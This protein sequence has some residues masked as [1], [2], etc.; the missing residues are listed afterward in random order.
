MNTKYKLVLGSLLLL[1]TQ[2]GY[3]FD[4][5]A[6]TYYFDNTEAKWNQVY[7]RI[8]QTGTSK[9]GSG[10]VEVKPMTQMAGNANIWSYTLDNSWNGAEAVQFADD[11]GCTSA[12]NGIYDG[13][14][15]TSGHK[16]EY[17]KGDVIKS[18]G[19]FLFISTTGVYDGFRSLY[20]SN[21]P[22]GLNASFAI[23]GSTYYHCSGT[24]HDAFNGKCIGSFTAG[25]TFNLNGEVST[26][27]TVSKVSATMNYNNNNAGFKQLN[28]KY[29]NTT[30]S[31]KKGTGNGVAIAVPKSAGKYNLAVYFQCGGVYDSNSGSNYT[32]YYYVPGMTASSQNFGT[33]QVSATKTNTVNI[34]GIYCDD[35]TKSIDAEIVGSGF[36]FDDGNTKKTISSIGAT[37]TSA[38]VKISFKPTVGDKYAAKLN[39]S[40][41][42]SSSEEK[43]TL[44]VD[45]TGAG[46]ANAVVLIGAEAEVLAGPSAT[47]HGYLQTTGCPQNPWTSKGFIYST[48]KNDITAENPTGTNLAA[49][50]SSEI[51]AGESWSAT[52][53]TL[54]ANT[55]YYY[56]AYVK[57]DASPAQYKYSDPDKYGQFTTKSA[58]LYPMVGDTVYV[59]VDNSLSGNDDC[60]LKYKTFAAA[61]TK[62]ITSDFFATN[63]LKY[64]VVM[65]VVPNKEQYLENVRIEGINNSNDY[66][67]VLII[68]SAGSERPTIQQ[69][70][71]TN[72]AMDI[73]VSKNI[74][75]DNIRI[76]SSGGKEA[77]TIGNNSNAWH[78]M[79][80][81]AVANAN[82]VIKNCYIESDGF[83]GVQMWAYDGV[84]FENNDIECKLGSAAKVDENTNYY[85]SSLK[86]QQTKNL[87]FIRNNFRGSHATSLWIQG[88]EG[89]LFMNNVFWNSNDSYYEGLKNNTCFVRLVTQFTTSGSGDTH[90]TANNNKNISM[91]YNTFFLADNSNTTERNVDF[92]RLGSQY[93]YGGKRLNNYLG[94]NEVS[95]IRFM[96]NNCYSYDKHGVK[97]SNN[98]SGD[99]NRWYLTTTESSWC[100][101]IN[102]NNFWSW[103]DNVAES[104]VSVFNIPNA[105]C[106]TPNYFVNV[107]EQVCSATNDPSDLIVKGGDMNFGSHITSDID[108]SGLNAS[109]YY[110]DRLYP[111]N[112]ADA[113]RK[114]NGKWTLGAYQQ[115]DGS[116]FPPV[117]V[118]TW[119][120]KVNSDWDNRGNWVK[121]NGKPLT[122]VDNIDEN[123]QVIIPALPEPE[124]GSENNYPKFPDKFSGV[125]TDRNQE[126]VNAGH[127][128]TTPTKF[129]SSI[130]LEY[131]AAIKNIEALNDDGTRHYKEAT[132]HFTA[133]REEWILVGTVIQPFTNESK[134]AVRLVQSGDYYL[135]HM[136][137]V[138]MHE[139]SF[140]PLTAEASWQTPFTQLDEQVPYDRVFAIKAADQYG[141]YKLTAQWYFYGK[142]EAETEGTAPKTFNFNGWFLND[143][144]MP[145]YELTDNKILSNTYPA[146]LDVEEVEKENNGTVKVYDYDPKVQDF[147]TGMTYI[148]PQ[149]GF[150]FV[151][152]G[153]NDGW[154]RITPEMLTNQSTTYKSAEAVNPT[155]KLRASNPNGTDGSSSVLIVYDELK[156][157][158]YVEGKDLIN[159]TIA[160]MPSKPEIY[161]MMYS[162]ELDKV[163]VPS[164][165]NAI[166]LGLKLEQAMT[167]DFTIPT[168]NDIETAILEDREA[169]K[170]YDL[171]KGDKGSISLAKGTYVGRFYLNLGAD[172]KEDIPTEGDDVT[173]S[174]ATIDLYGDGSEI[175]ISSSEDV[176]L[177]SAEITD[178]S[179]NT[180]V[181]TLK[182]AHYNRVK[183]N[184]AQGV[185]VVKAIGDTKTETAK[186]IVK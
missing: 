83:S 19:S 20:K 63:N 46:V 49:S 53:G 90:N 116:D 127:G 77:L 138:Y 89:G 36:T 129:A 88:L 163:I 126:T 72:D 35:N 92:F 8:G 100:N 4:V 29:D 57:N 141:T 67:K 16:S 144:V 166:P 133:G 167:V 108:K 112:G 170:S 85:G 56:R 140:N 64:N 179:G 34:T 3:A 124:L 22:S 1:V 106:S 101:S 99:A 184:G 2:L 94:Q 61:L 41:K 113:V 42:N 87:K 185:Y 17:L 102:R 118:L 13:D 162:K 142:P 173:S 128:M 182:N 60:A 148:K 147:E 131:G 75:I 84:T 149:N 31:K 181:V 45:L 168:M 135:G 65:Q 86:I 81:G 74:I 134:N 104:D 43:A 32:A 123:V 152:D 12:A 14:W 47:L 165:E 96:Y 48:T 25:T 91:F 105:G 119:T 58:C 143:A 174:T 121:E 55:T 80:P 172:E 10:V 155:L 111:S 73:R 9:G 171:L 28:L 76:V 69:S 160:G 40:L 164:L 26:T 93:E 6:G 130:E 21:M 186:V 27:G 176:I 44:S 154:F 103:L 39:L 156:S 157:D 178:M 66:S 177:K 51:L 71:G 62:I 15:I 59:T 98:N 68:R 50:G 82:I 146:T 107:Y 70:N 18:D 175:I 115:T 183:V 33:I 109:I 158:E 120:G 114:V 139:A 38:S 150:I 95:T 5:P 136:P 180:T 30:S 117:K 7:M 23:V 78:D 169:G 125:R 97:R 151:K 122:C 110:N 159:T 79:T 145:E 11:A 137:H 37:T 153:S 54:T 161:A 24:G 132:N 52:T